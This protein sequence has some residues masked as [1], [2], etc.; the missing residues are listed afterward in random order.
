MTRVAAAAVPLAWYGFAVV[1][2]RPAEIPADYWALARSQTG[3]RLELGGRQEPADWPTFARRLF[4]LTAAEGVPNKEMVEFLAYGDS[5]KGSHRFAAFDAEGRPLGV[6]YVAAEPV[7]A[8]RAWVCQQFDSGMLD[9]GARRAIL[10][11]RACEGNADPGPI[12]CSCF[13]VGRNQILAAVDAQKLASVD[14]VSAATSAGSNCGSCRAE[15]QGLI[16]HVT[17]EAA[18]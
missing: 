7:A 18:E 10:A 6:L 17:V 11:G 16:D 3:F 14:D 13:A 4:G 2:R 9:C 1:A 5:D 8:S 15:I 12:V